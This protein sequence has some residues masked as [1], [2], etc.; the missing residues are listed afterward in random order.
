M[1]IF[2][3]AMQ[4][5]KDGEAFYRELATKA[6]NQGVVSIL[7]LLADEEL[8]HYKAIEAIQ[9]EDYDMKDVDVLDHARNVFRQMKDFGTT[10]QTD[11]KAAELYKEAME[12]ERKSIDFYLDRADQMEKPSQKQLFLR[13]AEEE[14][15]HYR[16]MDNLAEFVSQPDAWLENAEFFH[17]KE[18]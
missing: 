7:N 5:E 10:F 16:L 3:F 2:A 1:D 12:I 6:D 15:K 11:V 4:M 18:Y 17:G 9:T 14:K 13:L 8:K